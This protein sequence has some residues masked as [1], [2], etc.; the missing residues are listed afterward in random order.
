M[1]V[2]LEL[3]ADG[4]DDI[5]IQVLKLSEETPRVPEQVVF[6]VLVVTDVVSISCEKVTEML[7]M[8][9]TPR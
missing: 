8:I 6:A 3:E 2:L 1:N 7:S 9:E 5:R 4:G